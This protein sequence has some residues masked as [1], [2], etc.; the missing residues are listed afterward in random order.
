MTLTDEDT[1]SKLDVDRDFDFLS[2]I[3]VW[4]LTQHWIEMTMATVR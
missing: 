2:C 4:K 1:S 3:S